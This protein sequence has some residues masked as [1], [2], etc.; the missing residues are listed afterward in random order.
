MRRSSVYAARD[1]RRSRRNAHSWLDGDLPLRAEEHVHAGSEFD[2]TDSLAGGH[3]VARLLAEDDAAGDQSG[4]L[5]EDHAR[6]VAFDGNDVLL[7]LSGALLATGDQKAAGLIL[8]RGDG[9]PDRRT[10]D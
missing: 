9:P 7:I 4:D 3:L 5:F 1:D 8:H 2:Q 10:I 6:A